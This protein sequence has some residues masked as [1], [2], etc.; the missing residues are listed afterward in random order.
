MDLPKLYH[1]VQ[2]H[3][4]LKTVIEKKR[5]SRIAEET[6]IVL[7]PR[8]ETKLDNVYVKYLLPYDTLSPGTLYLYLFRGDHI[9]TIFFCNARY[10]IINS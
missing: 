8:A 5:W 6:R 1:A 4:G 9:S 3:G 7:G 2:R 10:A